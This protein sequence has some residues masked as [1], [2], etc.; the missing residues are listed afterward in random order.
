MGLKTRVGLAGFGHR[1]GDCTDVE[2]I[3]PPE[4][5]DIPRLMAPL[6]Q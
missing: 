3:L 1:R 2:V 5:V 4:Q 6:E